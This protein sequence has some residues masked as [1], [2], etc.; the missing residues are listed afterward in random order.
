MK[1]LSKV[2]ILFLESVSDMETAT[3]GHSFSLGYRLRKKKIIRLSEKREESVSNKPRPIRLRYILAAVILAAVAVLA[4]FGVFELIKGF[5][6]TDY[7]THSFLDVIDDI[8]DA[9]EYLYKRFY[10]DADMSGYEKTIISDL[11]YQYWVKY[12]DG[13]QL[14]TVWQK[15]IDTLEYTH[16]NTEEALVP[17]QE[18]SINGWNGLWFKTRNEGYLYVFNTG[19]YIIE[20]ASNMPKEKVEELVKA[21]KLK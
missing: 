1:E 14:I 19:E 18:I 4:G 5:R 15:T 6:V 10:I 7:G 8:D 3:I 20:Y 11:T 16:Y 2:D 9:P 21:T 17:P 13:D 12:E